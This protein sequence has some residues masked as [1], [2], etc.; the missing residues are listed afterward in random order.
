MAY[1]VRFEIKDR[2]NTFE[3]VWP[4]RLISEE[5]AARLM[6]RLLTS[7]VSGKAVFLNAIDRVVKDGDHEP[8]GR[9][10]LASSREVLRWQENIDL[11]RFDLHPSQLKVCSHVSLIWAVRQRP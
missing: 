1:G 5:P 9:L 8:F 7:T 3:G 4:I 6:V 2:T 10:L 11:R